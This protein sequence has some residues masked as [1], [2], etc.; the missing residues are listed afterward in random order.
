MSSAQPELPKVLSIGVPA[1][2][3]EESIER[4]LKSVLNQT[5]WKAL[6]RERKEIIVCANACTDH[7]VDIVKR[8]QSAHPEIKLIETPQKGKTVAW[9]ILKENANTMAEAV[10][11]FDA[12][13]IVQRRTVQR[14]WS[15][16]TQNPE[17]YVVAAN[18][19]PT[20]ALL[21]PGK[22]QNP[23]SRF[24]SRTRRAQKA[25]GKL[26]SKIYGAGYAIRRKALERIS[27]PEEGNLP[28][29]IFLTG[30][31]G[32]N[33]IMRSQYAS[34]YYRAP[35]VIMDVYRER[36]RQKLGIAALKNKYPEIEFPKLMN[37]REQWAV[38]KSLPL[39]EKAYYALLKAVDVAASARAR[40]LMGKGKKD[41]WKKTKSTKLK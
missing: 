17:I 22:I 15:D 19:V 4:M 35:R 23:I 25:A 28:E 40:Q 31:I 21:S 14:L 33:K 37:L 9:N 29:D 10:F 16:L 26:E 13:V 32:R 6:P 41:V 12:D 20:A 2:N 27:M 24:Y 1:H 34:V 39:R 5:A 18:V 38:F 11:F 3:E 7:T 36:L 8:M 30:A